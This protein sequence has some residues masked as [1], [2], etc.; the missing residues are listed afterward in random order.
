MGLIP[1][2]FW[3]N[4]TKPGSHQAFR[5]SRMQHR[6][7]AKLSGTPRAPEKV[8]AIKRGLKQLHQLNQ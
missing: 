8:K 4:K 1:E 6:R 5:V 2:N 7:M 3:V